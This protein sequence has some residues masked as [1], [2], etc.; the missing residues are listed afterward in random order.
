MQPLKFAPVALALALCAAQAP[1]HAQATHA[2]GLSFAPGV[3][4]C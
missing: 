4:K 1:V 3:Y 2:N